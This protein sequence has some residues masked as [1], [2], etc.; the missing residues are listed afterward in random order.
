MT[1]VSPSRTISIAGKSYTLDGSFGTL[2]AVQEAF[3]RDIVQ[4]LIG[5]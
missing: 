5:I 2:R 1:L 4:V 3:N